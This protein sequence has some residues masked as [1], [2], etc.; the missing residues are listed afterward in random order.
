M[1]T[2]RERQLSEADAMPR[3]P[4]PIFVATKAKENSLTPAVDTV[5]VKLVACAKKTEQNSMVDQIEVSLDENASSEIASPRE[6]GGL[7][8]PIES[9]QPEVELQA[10]AGTT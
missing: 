1:D 8:L 5:D 2:E 3:L 10:L 4:S 7:V 6:E 9:D